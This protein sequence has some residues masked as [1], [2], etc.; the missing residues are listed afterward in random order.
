MAKEINMSKFEELKE[1][2][3]IVYQVNEGTEIGDAISALRS[4]AWAL[5]GLGD[6]QQASKALDV[7]ENLC[8]DYLQWLIDEQPG[9]EG[10]VAE[11]D[12]EVWEY[13]DLEKPEV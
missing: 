13:F 10:E 11:I 5:M 3:D 4:G 6:Y 7:V 2:Y 9:Y 12:D 1:R 8:K